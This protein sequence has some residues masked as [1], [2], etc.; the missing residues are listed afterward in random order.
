MSARVGVGF[1]G[2]GL[3]SQ[4]IHLPVIASL[5]ERARVVHVMDVDRR[6][7]EAVSRCAGAR[8]STDVRSVLEDPAVDIVVVC[9][10]HRFHAEQVVAAWEAGKRAVMCEKPLAT[11]VA[12][13]QRLADLAAR[14]GTLLV[15]GAMHAYDPAYVAATACLAN[16]D[17]PATLVRS[18]VYLPSNDEFVDLA[19]EPLEA[20]PPPGAAEVGSL[21]AREAEAVRAGILGLAVH[22]IPLV[23]QLIPTFEKVTM[24]RA[25][26]PWGYAVTIVSG[27]RSAQL[28]GLMPGKWG[29]E[30]S[31]SAWSP[32]YELRVEFPPSY[33]LAG[34]AVAWLT[35][36][37]GTRVWRYAENG[38]QA[39]WRCLVDAVAGGSA[40]PIPAQDAAS[41]LLYAL[42]VADGASQLVLEAI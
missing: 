38:Y 2:A 30:W 21:A 9:S 34:S 42:E 26:K 11:T 12:E 4:A 39:E 22:N 18:L 25:L 10:P 28:I 19:T 23:R 6:V 13:A 5:A 14:N 29:P 8:A 24:A 27:S 3:A 35:T 32:D 40:L 7:A 16:L 1:I 31:F 37:E 20:A 15:V 17:R 41:D 36:A 33:V